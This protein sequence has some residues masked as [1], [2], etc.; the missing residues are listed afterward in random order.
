MAGNN[1]KA[2][3]ENSLRE[4]LTQMITA[5][6][7]EPRVRAAS[8]LTVTKV[9]LNVDLSVARVYVS[10]VGEQRVI[11]G[12]MTGLTNAAGFLR[13]PVARAC[14]LPRPPELRFFHDQSIG[15]KEKMTEILRDDER[16]AAEVGRK[17]GD[18]GVADP[19][20]PSGAGCQ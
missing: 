2:R 10:L 12:V 20:E 16:R 5:D 18:A 7:K 11:D 13:G 17:A 1:R 3:V 6:G 8:L 15:M 9:E 14:S 4:V 19:V